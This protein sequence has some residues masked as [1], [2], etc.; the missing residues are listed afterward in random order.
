M[1]GL[2]VWL[3][4]LLDGT[5]ALEGELLEGTV[6]LDGELLCLGGCF[7]EATGLDDELLESSLFE[8]SYRE[9]KSNDKAN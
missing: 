1:K 8:L 2:F 7:G 4:K 6:A 3:K 9:P 5:V